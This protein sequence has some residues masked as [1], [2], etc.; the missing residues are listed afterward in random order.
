MILENPLPFAIQIVGKMPKAHAKA[1]V[2]LQ[3]VYNGSQVAL[4]SVGHD[5]IKMWTLNEIVEDNIVV[6]TQMNEYAEWRCGVQSACALPTSS[7]TG[8]VGGDSMIYSLEADDDG[9]HMRTYDMGYMEVW[10]LAVLE[11]GRFIT[12][13]FSGYLSEVIDG[14]WGVREGHP[15]IKS[16]V[17]MNLS[18]SGKVLALGG[19]EG[20]VD[21]VDTKTLKTMHTLEAHWSRIT[22]VLLLSDDQ[23]LTGG[24][25]KYIKYFKV[26]GGSHSLERTLCA[27][28]SAITCMVPSPSMGDT[29]TFASASTN[30]QIILWNLDSP[31]SPLTHIEVPHEGAVIALAFSPCGQFLVSGGDDKLLGV[32]RVRGEPLDESVPLLNSGMEMMEEEMKEEE[33]R[34]EINGGKENEEPRREIEREQNMSE[35]E[36]DMENG[37]AATT[38][39][40][41]G[42]SSDSDGGEHRREMEERREEGEGEEEEEEEGGGDYEGYGREE[43]REDEYGERE[44][45]GEEIEGEGERAEYG[46]EQREGEED[47]EG[48]YEE[49]ETREEEH[50]G[51][52]IDELIAG[53]E[54]MREEEGSGE[55]SDDERKYMGIKKEEPMYEGYGDSPPR[56]DNPPTTPPF[57]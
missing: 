52:C 36:M 18:P 46:E 4:C 54:E 44:E 29:T 33:M 16:V 47:G 8:V 45:G 23:L 17:C 40:L 55:G 19:A 57:E 28:R 13:S 5:S 21:I 27:H 22:S 9:F 38:R 6:F 2:N 26:S 24:I 35:D 3:F 7:C 53:E 30:G 50:G 56:H 39:D 31:G 48:R 15:K 1:L 49:G 32:Y 25:D 10:H 51:Y 12:T 41:F 37:G 34:E 20:S 14:K 42:D 43:E 11:P